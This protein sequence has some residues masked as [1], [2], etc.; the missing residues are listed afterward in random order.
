MRALMRSMSCSGESWWVSLLR[1][2]IEEGIKGS[3]EGQ[4]EDRRGHGQRIPAFVCRNH[5]GRKTAKI[6]ATADNTPR[7]KRVTDL[8]NVS[9]VMTSVRLEVIDCWACHPQNRRTKPT[10]KR[11]RPTTRPTSFIN[12]LLTMARASEP[13]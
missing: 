5:E 1:V 8:A 12:N 13:S 11:R 2:F 4:V 9:P 10:N 6:P 3:V 7:A